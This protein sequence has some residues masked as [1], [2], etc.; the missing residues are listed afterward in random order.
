MPAAEKQRACYPPPGRFRAQLQRAHRHA[1]KT[2]TTLRHDRFP[3]VT[4]T[5][6][7]SVHGGVQG[8]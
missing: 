6:N 5:T 2:G 3:I 8:T 1:E 4:E 7:W